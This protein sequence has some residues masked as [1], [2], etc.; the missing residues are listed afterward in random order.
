MD[1]AVRKNLIY[2]IYWSP[3]NGMLE[4]NLSL[5]ERYIHIF[6]G[7]V[8]CINVGMEEKYWS[9]QKKYTK[10][11]NKIT[12]DNYADNDPVNG[13]KDY[14]KY[15]LTLL[16][17]D[18]SITFYAHAKG[19]SRMV[20]RPLKWWV[21]LLYKGNLDSLPDMKNHIFS[22]CFGK[23]RTA[24]TQCP[25]EF[26]YSGSF[27][28]FKTKEVLERYEKKRIIPKEIDTRWFTENFPA[29]IAKEHECEFRLWSGN[30][31][32]MNFYGD[33]WWAKHPE[34]RNKAL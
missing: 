17:K 33:K 15:A 9:L 8:I 30:E 14:F 21:K 28:W 20:N 32:G 7:E 29:F 4:Y 26:H 6:D 18:D 11:T 5:L 1:N 19:V 31:R 25:L 22:G 34:I 16:P 24:S 23:L 3:E 12:I 10:F 13:E 27:F 2:F